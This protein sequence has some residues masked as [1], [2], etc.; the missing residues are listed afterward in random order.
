MYARFADM[1]DGWTK[2]L[3]L[4]YEKHLGRALM[5]VIETVVLDVVLLAA[6]LLVFARWFWKRGLR[7]YSGASA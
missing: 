5:G 2:N 6:F 4:L 1:W 7:R 3:Y